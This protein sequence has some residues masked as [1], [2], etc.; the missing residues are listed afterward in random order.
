MPRGPQNQTNHIAKIRSQV[1]NLKPGTHLVVK[2]MDKQ[3]VRGQL[4]ASDAD[5]F[6]LQTQGSLAA[7]RRVSFAEIKSVTRPSSKGLRAATFIIAGVV[8]AA[9]VIG[10]VF[11]L[12]ERHNE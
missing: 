9:V 11:L 2:L 8:V 6:T 4:G 10:V 5:G 3:E 12:A 1:A 7:E